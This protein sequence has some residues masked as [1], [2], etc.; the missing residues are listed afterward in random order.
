MSRFAARFIA[1]IVLTLLSVVP[2]QAAAQVSVS[3]TPSGG[4]FSTSPLNVELELCSDAFPILTWNVT[5]N[6]SDVSTSFGFAGAAQGCTYGGRYTAT[7]NLE[8][9]ANEISADAWDEADNFGHGSASYTFQTG[10]NP[11]NFKIAHA[12][13]F[14]DASRCVADCFE[15]TASYS[16][17]TYTSLGVARGVTLVYRSDRA[18]PRGLV[19]IDATDA[20]WNT[21]TQYSLRLRRPDL[22]FVQ[23][24]GGRD[25]VFFNAESS[26]WTRLAVQFDASGLATQAYSYTAVIRTYYSGGSS[27]ETTVPV[28]V[29]IVNGASSPYG[30]GWDIAGMQR[31]TIQ[32]NDAQVASGDGSVS[33]FAGCGAGCQLTSP[34]GD[35]S[36]LTSE[37]NGTFTRRYPD[38]TKYF[39]NSS[40]V[41]T[42]VADRFGFGATF[43]YN[44]GGLLTSITDP[45]GAA[46]AVGYDGSNRLA[47]V[48]TPG[49]PSR[50][51]TFWVNSTTADLDSIRDPDNIRNLRAQYSGHRIT[52]LTDRKGGNWTHTYGD[53]ARLASVV[54]PQIV[55]GGASATPTTT[56]AGPSG[57][58]LAFLAQG[59]THGRS[60][61]AVSNSHD[62]RAR[63]TNPRNN[64]TYFTV[65]RWGSPGQVDAPLSQT[66]TAQYLETTGQA[67]ETISAS[68]HRVV[69]GWT[70]PQ[71]TSMND[72]TAGRTV[73]MTYES[74]FNRPLTVTGSAVPQTFTYPDAKTVTVTTGTH[75]AATIKLDQ[76][77]RDSV[78]TDPGGHQTKF[79]YATSGLRNLDSVRAVGKTSYRYDSYGRVRAV[80]G[81]DGVRDS[82]TYDVLNRVVASTNGMN[83]TTTFAFADNV[84]LTSVTDALSNQ[85]TFTR[86]ALGWVTH[87]KRA[88]SP[89][90]IKTTYDVN[91]NVLTSTNRREQ[92]VSFVYDN[93]DRMTSRSGPDI[94]TTTFG[95]QTATASVN[96]Y[97]AT[98]NGVSQD[99]TFVN[100]ADRIVAAKIVRG[101]P[102]V[103]LAYTYTSLGQR[104]SIIAT[105]SQFSGAKI[106]AFAFNETGALNGISLAE[107]T[108]SLD[109]GP[110]NENL[111]RTFGYHG[112]LTMSRTYGALHAGVVTTYDNSTVQATLGQQVGYDQVGRIGRVM[113]PATPNYAVTKALYDNAR[114]LQRIENW[115][116]VDPNC[117]TE[118]ITSCTAADSTLHTEGTTDYTYDATG[119]RL[120]GVTQPIGA[121]NRVTQANGFTYAYDDDGNLT[122]KTGSGF[123]ETLTW[124][125][126]GQLASSTSNGVTIDYGYDGWGRLART[127]FNGNNWHSVYDGD[128]LFMEFDPSAAL[129]REYSYWGLDRPH[130]MRK[131]D[132]LYFVAQH[133]MGGSVAGLIRASD[134]LVA[135]QFAYDA[136]G[137][138][139][140]GSDP[141][142]MPLRFAGRQWL[143]A[144]Q[145]YYHRNRWYDPSLGRFISEDPIG[146][147]GGINLYTYAGNDPV[148]GRDP[149][150]LCKKGEYEK[151]RLTPTE[152][153]EWI[154]EKLC[155]KGPDSEGQWNWYVENSSRY[156][157][158]ADWGA[159]T[160]NDW[161]VN[162]GAFLEAGAAA[163]GAFMG[164]GCGEYSCGMGLPVGARLSGKQAADL[165]RYLG[166]SRRVK[167]PPFNSMGEPVFSNGR[168][169]ISQ[170]RTMHS[171][172][173]ATW[174]V[175]DRYGNRIGTFD[176]LLIKL[177][178]K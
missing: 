14:R 145:L 116:F 130:S 87:E 8:P 128:D 58:I 117:P 6:G 120:N 32:G 89:D 56:F 45:T 110:L 137:K 144:T 31:L 80:V 2:S 88:G 54:A 150:G 66:S 129:A 124:N 165:A 105:S 57:A 33:F 35:F 67:W 51:S 77:G 90:T 103:R 34:P 162:L 166:F 154:E 102:W 92:T 20:A 24:T 10:G 127:T 139:T 68:S 173:D 22:S 18:N 136:F 30:A 42:S 7:L 16:T 112:G 134:N 79:Y 74:T 152:D 101:G 82:V 38:G 169:L 23:F 123:S 143:P 11:A 159:R 46:I 83:N 43:G 157:E 12:D 149:F 61:D 49:S 94:P 113:K 126:L 107:G 119:N 135:S 171:G 158:L 156:Q 70:G 13:K 172:V 27:M 155:S 86:N 69:L 164:E 122:T 21:V 114:R 138:T 47:S 36:T 121:G 174:K 160:G 5:F 108:T 50:T 84:F 52:T 115:T 125:A 178:G 29:M 55:A 141:V 163:I 85:T 75:P 48:T 168:L 170:D 161:A 177:L 59:G 28:K 131:N 153:G 53:D 99:T 76:F 40:G 146:I 71:L 147:D 93:L 41:L 15:A 37:S 78:I 64:A 140:G 96:G 65:N 176:A 100:A 25:T 1:L 17:P 104:D 39:F 97:V 106:Q 133:P 151:I 98:D 19:E 81:P 142:G 3:F 118:E 109:P 73:S 132:T 60:S 26:A 63:V 148:N 175:F 9:G 72:V 4:T 111:P 95:Y 91:G 62:L 44:G 167:S